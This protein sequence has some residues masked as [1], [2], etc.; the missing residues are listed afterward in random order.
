MQ[1]TNWRLCYVIHEWPSYFMETPKE[2]IHSKTKLGLGSW[3]MK[4]L[5]YFTDCLFILTVKYW[6]MSYC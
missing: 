4:E 1:S 3:R 6:E 2:A 5:G